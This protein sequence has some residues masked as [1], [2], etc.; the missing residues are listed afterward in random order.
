MTPCFSSALSVV[1]TRWRL[2]SVMCR[3]G[4][5]E[6]SDHQLGRRIRGDL[7]ARWLCYQLQGTLNVW[8]YWLDKI[9]P[10]T[11]RTHVSRVYEIVVSAT[12]FLVP[13]STLRSKR[14][15][16]ECNVKRLVNFQS[17]LVR[18]A[19]AYVRPV[20]NAK[21]EKSTAWDVCEIITCVCR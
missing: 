21:L 5:V 11:N 15:G 18:V 16:M 19:P 10:L 13:L 1:A 12:I 7:Y 14:R 17:A 6:E 8:R 2:N 4:W 9:I 3:R 20:K